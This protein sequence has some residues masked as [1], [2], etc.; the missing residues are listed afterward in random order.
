MQPQPPA[1]W[2]PTP[3]AAPPTAPSAGDVAGAM[4][5]RRDGRGLAALL[6][7]AA[8]L[9]LTHLRVVKYALEHQA[10]LRRL[11]A[12]WAAR[13]VAAQGAR[14]AAYFLFAKAALGEERCMKLSGRQADGGAPAGCT[15][16]RCRYAH[17]CVM[18]GAR[19]HGWYDAAECA[20]AQELQRGLAELGWASPGS[21]FMPDA[22]VLAAT[23]T[24]PYV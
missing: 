13:R 2:Q 21:P 7:R 22:V 4:L 18:C 3:L 15:A 14:F 10:A 24:A 8:P 11:E 16:G 12:A 23:V 19:D 9:V 17:G 20:A 5:R 6:A 1:Q